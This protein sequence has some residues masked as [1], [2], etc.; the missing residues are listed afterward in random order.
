MARRYLARKILHAVATLID[1]DV[2]ELKHEY[3][4]D[5]PLFPQQFLNYSGDVLRFDL[6]VSL[7]TGVRVSTLIAVRVW[8]TVL[9]VGIGTLL[10]TGLGVLIGIKG[11][12]ERGSLF[13]TSTLYGS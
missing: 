4:L 11:G 9:L 12:W 2:A 10:A 1:A 8:P 3:G 6:G 13:D 5:E 7:R